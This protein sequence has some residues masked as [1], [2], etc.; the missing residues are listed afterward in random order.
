MDLSEEF[1]DSRYKNN[2]TGWDLGEISP[3]LK[4]YI[5]QLAN[6]ELKILIPGGGN[7]YEA[8][9]LQN[10]GFRNVFVADISHTVLENIKKRVPSFPV[11]HLI[12][13]NFFELEMTF[14]VIIEQTFFC[15]INPN[16]RP[17]YVAK[18]FELLNKNGAIV[19]LLFDVPLNDDKPPFGGC[20]AEYIEHF[21]P[22]FDI[23]IMESA[24]NSH[25]SR[26]DRELFIKLKKA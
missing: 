21:R 19:G 17:A 11:S 13:K 15:A 14:D 26:K 9:Y 1:W 16:L 23:S 6:K 3:P 5:D 2:D 22:Y 4:A 10:K 18:A 20:K 24:Y 12:H 25:H 7:S 8:E